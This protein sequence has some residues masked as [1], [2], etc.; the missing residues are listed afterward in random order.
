MTSPVIVLLG[1]TAVGK[2]DLSLELAL[3]LDAEIVNADSMQLYEG[4]DIGTAKV[5]LEDRRGV[6]HHL[7]D[8]WPVT[9]LA[10]VAEFQSLAREQISDIH[11]RGKIALVVGG[12][13]LFIQAIL[14]DLQ[15]PASDDSVRQRLI[16][17]AEEVGIG[18]LYERFMKLAPQ[19]AMR[20]LPTNERRVIRALEVIELTGQ[21]PQ[22][23]LGPLPPVLPSVRLGLIRSRDE[24]DE[25]IELRV[26]HM[27]EQGF[28]QEV[29]RLCDV[30]LREGKTAAKAL[31]YAQVLAA[32]DGQYNLETAKLATISATKKFARRQESW[33]RRDSSIIW[34][35]AGHAGVE[36]LLPHI[37]R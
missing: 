2:T 36:Q 29:E 37:P 9:H 19:A 32:L 22:T 16:R 17:E 24:L 1:P 33:F 5:L 6:P 18:A 12:S 8:V 31:G 3:E 4:M 30:G 35:D 14:E 7:L 10:H 11:S 27:W 15:F 28:V 23:Q 13:G 20:V 26:E 25:R 21:A 34:I